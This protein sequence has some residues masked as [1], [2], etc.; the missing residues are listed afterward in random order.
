MYDSFEPGSK[1][2]LWCD[3][4]HTE[5]TSEPSAKKRETMSMPLLPL[6][7]DGSGGGG[8][9]GGGSWGA[10]APPFRTEQALNA[11]VYR[12]LRACSYSD[13]VHISI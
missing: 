9:G 11:E 4:I 2:T 1:I 13:T 6:T 8:G 7:R 10:H 5:S 3:G 12:A